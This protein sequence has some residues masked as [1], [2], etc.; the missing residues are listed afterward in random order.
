MFLRFPVL[1][2]SIAVLVL[3]IAVL[4][5]D[6]RSIDIESFV[7]KDSLCDLRPFEYEYEYRFTEYEYEV[8]RT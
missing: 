1:V 8:I 4:V 3:S 6:R 7:V 2:L 5:L